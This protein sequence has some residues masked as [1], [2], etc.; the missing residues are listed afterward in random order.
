MNPIDLIILAA[1]L[2]VLGLMAILLH[3]PGP[4][5]H[6]LKWALANVAS[7]WG[8][9][10]TIEKRRD[11]LTAERSQQ[12]TVMQEIV[13]NAKAETRAITDEEQQRYN[14][15]RDR[16][17][18]IDTELGDLAKQVRS[19][20]LLAG[21]D[22]FI[23]RQAPMINLITEPA[24][25]EGRS[26]D[27]LLWASEESVPAG[28]YNRNGM[29]LPNPYG[30]R[31][32]VEQV[33]VRN[34]DDEIAVAPRI[35]EFQ[36]EARPRLRQFQRTVGDMILFGL[37]VDR[38]AR[39]SRDGFLA[40]KTHKGM[41]ARFEQALRALDVDTSGEGV[42]WVPTGIGADLHEKVRAAGRVAP[43]FARIDLPTNPWKWPLEGGD[44]TAY[45]VPEPTSDSATKVTASTPGTGAATFDAEIF[46]GRTLFSRSLEADSA[47]AVLPYVR[48]KLVRAFIDAE[49]KAI[50]DGDTDGTH[51]DSDVG[52]STTDARTAWD[53]LRKRGLAN[54]SVDGG[55]ATITLA[56]FRAA[57]AA[58]LKWG[59]NPAELAAIMSIGVYYDLLATTEVTTVDKMGAQA[60]I[61]N[62]QLGAL[63]G[64]PL[65]VSE[66]F[67]EDLNASGVHDGITETQTGLVIV[68]R[69]EW[70]LGQR[71]ALDVEVDDSI[72]RET[73]QRVMVAFMREDFQNIGE[74]A[75][76][77]TA[78]LYNLD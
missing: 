8:E 36:P 62:G 1:N 26:L 24:A 45:R 71:M 38:A 67:R 55:S 63:D 13:D 12:L 49:E 30:A 65:I 28:S 68:N 25:G 14:T 59:L 20:Q 44:A 11:D 34:D 48:N 54:T 39:S 15:A 51:Q 4:L 10:T 77:D 57:R 21:H 27:E 9:V 17:T 2:G 46:G 3:R 72:Y 7:E 6:R 73:F 43:L 52:A 76:D 23:S 74:S 50:I 33:T 5:G 64:T 75:G 66:H 41:R 56:L 18:E 61:L 22:E 40:A 42:E 19:D 47:L 58:M 35:T 31:N 60:T 29:F 16:V 69:G 53:G 70:A 37:M 78:Y 32:A